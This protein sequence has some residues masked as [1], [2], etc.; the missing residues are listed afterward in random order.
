M[1]FI[2]PPTSPLL[3]DEEF[4]DERS[5]FI[6]R[7]RTLA[8]RIRK[9]META[10]VSPMQSAWSVEPDYPVEDWQYEVQNDD[11][12][13]GY[14]EWVE[15]KKEAAE[16]LRPD[17]AWPTYTVERRLMERRIVWS[18]LSL[19]APDRESAIEIATEMALDD[20]GDWIVTHEELAEPG[21]DEYLV[22]EAPAM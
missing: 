20:S 8:N 14:G 6:A 3:S 1:L 18:R 21:C 16:E 10:S 15:A 2:E 22:I 7:L 13:L 9:C 11:T 19:Q 12:R 17:P 4:I 5:A